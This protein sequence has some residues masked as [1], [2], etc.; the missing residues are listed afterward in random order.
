MVPVALVEQE[1]TLAQLGWSPFDIAS[2][3]YAEIEEALRLPRPVPDITNSH[4]PP[5]EVEKAPLP[6]DI[7]A[8]DAT[9]VT[10]TSTTTTTTH[11]NTATTA[12]ATAAS[13][14]TPV[15][16]SPTQQLVC[17]ITT[18][19]DRINQKKALVNDTKHE[20]DCSYLRE[21]LQADLECVDRCYAQARAAHADLVRSIKSRQTMLT[22]C[23]GRCERS[24]QELQK[25]IQISREDELRL[26]QLLG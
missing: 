1:R 16:A 25:R 7:A 6:A 5:V 20:E 22:I 14:C 18:L 23:G 8:S 11:I 4:A 19:L 12:T 15:P 26:S 2:A 13:V 24:D 21:S 9:I 17:T 10:S 3:S